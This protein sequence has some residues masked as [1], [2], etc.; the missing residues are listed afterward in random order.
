MSPRA[1]A[2]TC[3][4]R[5][6]ARVAAAG[7]NYVVPDDIKALA[8]TVLA[9]R[10]A[11]H[12]RG[13]T[14]RHAVS[15]VIGEVLRTVPVPSARAVIWAGSERALRVVLHPAR[16]ACRSSAPSSSSSPAALL[17]VARAVRR[18]GRPRPLLRAV[19][20]G[21]RGAGAPA[22][23]SRTHGDPAARVTRAARAGSSCPS[24]TTVYRTTPVV[25]MFDP[26]TGTVAP[27]CS[28][29][30]S[31]PASRPAPR[32]ACRPRSGASCGS[33]RSMSSSP[34]RSASPRRATT[35]GAGDRAHGVPV[36]G[37]H[38]ARSRTPPAT[39]RTPAQTIRR[40]SAG[41]ARTSTPCAPT[42]SATIC[43]GCTGSPPRAATS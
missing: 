12:A 10:L 25:R 4:A 5:R 9:H 30:R 7:R 17:G 13:T 22:A 24:A 18:S 1:V 36:G 16:L 40:R 8:E 27:T 33:A 14:R 6:G 38:R 26:V 28:S 3:S 35:R 42:S 19:L 15:D 32:T 39:T 31:S 34:T 29:S 11:R 43:G 23:R 2:A 37:R 20:D 41:P 21:G